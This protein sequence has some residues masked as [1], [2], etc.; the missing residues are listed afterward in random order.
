MSANQIGVQLLSGDYAAG[1]VE[2]YTQDEGWSVETEAGTQTIQNGEFRSALL[3]D[4]SALVTPSFDCL[5][6]YQNGALLKGSLLNV[7]GGKLQI[8]VD[9]SD[10]PLA[11]AI[12]GD[13]DI[14]VCF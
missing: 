5:V 1:N 4:Q 6:R 13:F 12:G 8:K 11:A 9:Y 10:A 3:L 14:E 2:S 7:L